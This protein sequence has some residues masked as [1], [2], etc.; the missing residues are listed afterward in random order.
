MPPACIDEAARFIWELGSDPLLIFDGF[1][2]VLA[3]PVKEAL[4]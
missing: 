3:R 2:L 4:L 1:L